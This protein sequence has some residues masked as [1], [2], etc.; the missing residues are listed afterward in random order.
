MSG[1]VAMSKQIGHSSKLPLRSS[2][3]NHGDLLISFRPSLLV[4][5]KMIRKLLDFKG[6]CHRFWGVSVRNSLSD[7]RHLLL[8]INEL[9]WK[10]NSVYSCKTP[11][12]PSNLE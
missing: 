9:M 1:L 4:L 11:S 7:G 2:L 5:N 3:G 12:I 10:L 8:K 6:A